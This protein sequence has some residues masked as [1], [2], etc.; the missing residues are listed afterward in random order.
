MGDEVVAVAIRVLEFVFFAGAVG[1]AIVV[2]LV[3]I[4]DMIE[5]FRHEAPESNAQNST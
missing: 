1:S 2:V 5:A 4:E 3:T